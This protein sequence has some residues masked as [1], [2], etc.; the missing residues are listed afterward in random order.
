MLKLDNYFV[1]SM[2]KNCSTDFQSGRTTPLRE[3]EK[4]GEPALPSPKRMKKAKPEN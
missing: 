2:G 1:Q 4:D 3:L